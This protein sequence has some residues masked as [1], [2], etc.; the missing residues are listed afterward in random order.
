M[1]HPLSLLGKVT[2]DVSAHGRTTEA[3]FCVVQANHDS[4]FSHRTASELGL[5]HV[6]YS[7]DIL[8]PWVSPIVVKPKN[9]EEICICINMRLPNQAI[10]RERETHTFD[11]W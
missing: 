7:A 2:T 11:Q 6:V 1:Q 5:I 10:L 3:T 4:L 8:Q 9:P